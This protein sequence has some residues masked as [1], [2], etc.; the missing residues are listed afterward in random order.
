[1]SGNWAPTARPLGSA[2]AFL[3]SASAA[4]VALAATLRFGGMATE[5]DARRRGAG[6][7]V[8][9]VAFELVRARRRRV[10]VG[11]EERESIIFTGVRR[12]ILVKNWPT[13]LQ[14]RPT[15]NAALR[16]AHQLPA[17]P[18]HRPGAP[19]HTSSSLSAHFTPPTAPFRIGACFARRR[20]RCPA[21]PTFSRCRPGHH[22]LLHRGKRGD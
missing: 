20:R 9:G 18:K 22:Q 6:Q 17:W 14:P 11:A 4:S 1:M 5:E 12:P 15:H 16:H 8:V 10:E 21:A 19:A 2:L 3:V 13:T 7:S